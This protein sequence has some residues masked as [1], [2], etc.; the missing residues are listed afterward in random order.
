M[1]RDLG[2][3]Y[4]EIM[5]EFDTISVNLRD[6]QDSLNDEMNDLLEFITKES[7]PNL[8]IEYAFSLRYGIPRA[9][10][11]MIV[12]SV[13][14]CTVRFEDLSYPDQVLVHWIVFA[15]LHQYSRAPFV[16]IDLS[17]VPEDVIQMISPLVEQMSK[18]AQLFINSSDLFH[19]KFAH[20]QFAP[21]IKVNWLRII[22]Y[23]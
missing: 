9:A 17:N 11:Q 20:L 5:A 8:T 10:A 2:H 23:F 16:F 13:N 15:A 19:I 12:Y 1:N 18:N 22:C 3:T 21:N 14:G 4:D 6:K 7:Y